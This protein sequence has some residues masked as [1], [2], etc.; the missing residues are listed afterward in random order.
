MQYIL[1]LKKYLIIKIFPATKSFRENIK[2]WV[3]ARKMRIE[4]VTGWWQFPLSG[5]KT[6]FFRWHSRVVRCILS[7][8]NAFDYKFPCH[9]ARRIFSVRGH[10]FF[11]HLIR[12]ISLRVNCI[13]VACSNAPPYSHDT[14]SVP[15]SRPTDASDMHHTAQCCS[16]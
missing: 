14:C 13:T 12:T 6:F 9:L 2:L 3:S 7:I 16:Q 1:I 10:G 4:R 15:F 8:G 11:G 5:N